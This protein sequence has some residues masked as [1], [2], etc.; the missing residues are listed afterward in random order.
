MVA[1]INFEIHAFVEREWG[2]H[3]HTQQCNARKLFHAGQNDQPTSSYSM[4]SSAFSSTRVGGRLRDM[5]ANYLLCLLSL[6]VR[7]TAHNLSASAGR[8]GGA[9]D[10]RTASDLILLAR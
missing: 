7:A 9:D 5:A 6:A 10:E 2:T 1:I 3:A 4:I 8:T